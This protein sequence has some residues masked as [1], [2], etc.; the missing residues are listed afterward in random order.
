MVPSRIRN[1]T[2]VWRSRSLSLTQILLVSSSL[3][4]HG[5]IGKAKV[6]QLQRNEGKAATAEFNAIEY[7]NGARAH[8]GMDVKKLRA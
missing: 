3:I 5:V 7:I 6:R 4:T 1:G 8:F 2:L